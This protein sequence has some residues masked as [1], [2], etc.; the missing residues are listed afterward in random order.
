MLK[1]ICSDQIAISRTYAGNILQNDREKAYRMF[2]GEPLG[3]EQE[4][5]SHII[6][7]DLSDMIDS[8]VA[9]LQPGIAGD[10]WAEFESVGQD[11]EEQS[12]A[13]SAAVNSV[14]VE[15]NQGFYQIQSAIMDALQ[16]ANGTVKVWISDKEVREVKRF[17]GLMPEQV[18]MLESQGASLVEQDDDGTFTFEMKVMEQKLNVRRV[19]PEDFLVDPN[20]AC[21]TYEDT[22]WLA[23]RCLLTRSDLVE[24]GFGRRMV[25]NLPA[26]TLDTEVD[27][28]AKYVEGQ[29]DPNSKATEDQDVIEIFECYLRAT[30][31]GKTG[32]ASLWKVYYCYQGNEV[33]SFEKCDWIPYATGAPFLVPGRWYGR[34]MYHKLKDVVYGKTRVLRQW[35]D[36]NEAALNCRKYIDQTRVNMD[37]LLSSRLNGVVRCKG[38]PMESVM[39]EP[40]TDVATSAQQLLDYFDKLRSERCGAAMDVMQPEAQVMKSVSGVS[41][42][43]QLSSTEMMSTMIARTLSETLI[44]NLFILVHETLRRSWSGPIPIKIKG[45]WIESNPAEWRPRDR[46]NTKVGVSPGERSKRTGALNQ[47]LSYQ[48]Q[49]LQSGGANI[50]VTLNNVHRLL[51]DLGKA[52]GLDSIDSYWIDPESPES[53]QAQEQ[54]GQQSQQQAQ[55]QMQAQQLAMQMEQAKIEIDKMKVEYDRLDDIADNEFDRLKL[56]AEIEVKEAELVQTGIDSIRAAQSS[57]A[58]GESGAGDSAQA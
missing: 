10:C 53:Q 27:Q 25:N 35:I 3:N 39:L 24:M 23:E 36:G 42:E 31:S 20:Q 4:G 52:Q 32:I 48:M 6:S 57:D 55:M 34:S 44:R 56:A 41:A 43:V 11:D 38:A 58:A 7:M 18:A 51:I 37:D 21:L 9:Q 15:G 13:E 40:V 50:M 46:V 1:A 54:M 14:I 30:S 26:H 19:A 16:A 8:T 2:Q 45:Q 29:Q 5:R 12:K 22:S 28:Q 17:E 33:L 49:L 47:Q